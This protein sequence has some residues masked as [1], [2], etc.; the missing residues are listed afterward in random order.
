MEETKRRRF[1]IHAVLEGEVDVSE[2]P[3]DGWILVGTYPSTDFRNASFSNNHGSEPY[4]YTSSVNAAVRLSKADFIPLSQYA[5][6]L[7]KL[8]YDQNA[9]EEVFYGINTYNGKAM[10]RVSNNANIGSSDTK[11]HGWYSSGTEFAIETEFN[12]SPVESVRINFS[13]GE[14]HSTALTPDQ[15]S[16]IKL[17][18]KEQ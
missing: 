3:G 12:S 15:I 7:C 10:T 18:V 17:Y 2:E 5:G 1:I 14:G 13:C 11:S 8:E 16:N 9:A 4:P 6:Y